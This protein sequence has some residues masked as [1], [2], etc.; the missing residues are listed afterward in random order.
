MIKWKRLS[1]GEYESS[2]GRFYIL[3][4]YDRIYGDHWVLHDRNEPDYYK[5]RYDEQTLLECKLKAEVLADK[6][7][8]KGKEKCREL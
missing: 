4:G 1:A 2:D 5:G 8:D 3:K 6:D 7:K